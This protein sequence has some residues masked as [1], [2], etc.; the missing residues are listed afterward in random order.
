MK[1]EIRIRNGTQLSGLATP[2]KIAEL[3]LILND[4][5]RLKIYLARGIICQIESKWL[6]VLNDRAEIDEQP[7][8]EANAERQIRPVA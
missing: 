7:T 8:K 4:S 1:I 2:Q 6:H 5:S 3:G